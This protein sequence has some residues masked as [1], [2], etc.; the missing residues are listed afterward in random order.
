MPGGRESGLVSFGFVRNCVS[1]DAGHE[2]VD[3]GK[4]I[5]ERFVREQASETHRKG[6]HSVKEPFWE[7]RKS[8]KNGDDLVDKEGR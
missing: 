5:A 7:E 4:G 6:H 1:N 2:V 3:A 8:S